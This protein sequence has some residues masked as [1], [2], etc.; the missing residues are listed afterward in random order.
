MEKKGSTRYDW[1]IAEVAYGKKRD[2]GRF[3][4]ERRLWR[5]LKEKIDG[6]WSEK[7]LQWPVRM[8]EETEE[9]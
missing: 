3:R 1:I 4:G 7:G 5:D 9:L 8:V 2:L 6:V